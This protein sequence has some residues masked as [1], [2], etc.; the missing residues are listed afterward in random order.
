MW[1]FKIYFLVLSIYKLT[2]CAPNSITEHSPQGSIY[3]SKISYS[4]KDKSLEPFWFEESNLNNMD[5]LYISENP[6]VVTKDKSEQG[7][8]YETKQYSEADE[9]SLHRKMQP[10]YGTRNNVLKAF[11]AQ[12]IPKLQSYQDAQN[13]LQDKMKQGFHVQM[14]TSCALHRENSVYQADHSIR[15]KNVSVIPMNEIVPKEF[16]L[17]PDLFHQSARCSIF[18]ELQNAK[19]QIWKA[20][21]QFYWRLKL[22]TNATGEFVSL[23]KQNHKVINASQFA[24]KSKHL[25]SPLAMESHL[26]MGADTDHWQRIS[27]AIR[28]PYYIK[29]IDCLNLDP[30]QFELRSFPHS[31]FFADLSGYLK[32]SLK[33]WNNYSCR[34]E[35]SIL[36][37]SLSEEV[38][39][40]NS[41]P[42]ARTRTTIF[43]DPIV[44]Y[45]QYK[46]STRALLVNPRL[47]TGNRFGFVEPQAALK[48]NILSFSLP[49]FALDRSIAIGLKAEKG[50]LL[51]HEKQIGKTIFP[52]LL[53]EHKV[54]LHLEPSLT[55]L[56]RDENFIYYHLPAQQN[57]ELGISLELKKSCASSQTS[58]DINFI[59]NPSLFQFH[60]MQSV[61]SWQ[62]LKNKAS[63]ATHMNFSLLKDWDGYK[64]MANKYIPLS[65]QRIAKY[66]KVQKRKG[67]CSK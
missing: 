56:Y 23:K 12:K 51:F 3:L 1:Y 35:Y 13:W 39:P 47:H 60:L 58:M 63:M 6:L 43:S 34:L 24:F 38:G 61:F 21:K 40:V 8:L 20:Q 36:A 32:S 10:K 49:S 9:S 25:S 7:S 4:E 67:P 15:K 41:A 14:Q 26:A 44:F 37:D 11:G 18:L 30:N 27:E 57:L 53:T 19:K 54:S 66:V 64:K 16:L 45:K 5:F 31:I 46:L 22:Q 50:A 2:A 59:L 28:P 65:S 48:Y 42:I 29:L 62:D 17:H 52:M 55:E 33:D